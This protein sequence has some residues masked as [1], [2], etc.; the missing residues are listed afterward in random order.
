MSSRRLLIV[1]G[2]L[3]GFLSIALLQRSPKSISVQKYVAVDT[4]NEYSA[5]K[6][7]AN[8]AIISE[9]AGNSVKNQ[10]N[11][12]IKDTLFVKKII[13]G[14]EL[15]SISA[16]GFSI[17]IPIGAVK[18]EKEI[19]IRGLRYEDIHTLDAS[20]INVT[21][22]YAGYR[23]L[24]H[25]KF[26][27]D[28][29]LSIGYDTSLIPEGYY[30][31]DIRTFF[32]DEEKQQWENLSIDSIDFEKHIIISKTDHFTDFINGILKQPE[33]PDADQYAPTS[34]RNLEYANPLEGMNIM[35]PPTANNSGCCSM[36]FPIEVPAG[37]NGMTPQ[38][39]IS[40]NSDVKD[41]IMG[42]G[43]S[44]NIPSITVDTRWGVPPYDAAVESESYLVNGEAIV[45][46]II[47]DGEVSRSKPLYVENGRERNVSGF[48]NYAYLTEGKFD[49]ITRIGTSPHNYWWEII[50]RNGMQYIFGDSEQENLS[51]FQYSLAE[52]NYNRNIAMWWLAK[53]KD[54]HGN[55]I[56]YSY[57]IGNNPA[58]NNQEPES[59]Y[60]RISEI[61]YTA[62]D[63]PRYS[64]EASY[65]ITFEYEESPNM[66]QLSGMYGFLTSDQ[67]LL[68][69][70]KIKYN[71]NFVKCYKFKYIEGALSKKVLNAIAEITNER[72][73]N[74]EIDCSNNIQKQGFYVHCFDYYTEDAIYFEQGNSINIPTGESVNVLGYNVAGESNI[75]KNTSYSIAGGGSACAGYNDG[76]LALKTNT[77]GVN[78]HYTFDIN[79][80]KAQLIDLNG[81]GIVDRVEKTVNNNVRFYKG[82]WRNGS[83]IEFEPYVA[84]PTLTKL[85]KSSSQTHSVGSEMLIGLGSISG[86]LGYS[87]S[88]MK[89]INSCYF[90]DVNG[91]GFVDYVSD[92]DV[93]INFPDEYGIPQ[94]NSMNGIPATEDAM[95]IAY[96]NCYSFA[97]SGE[98]NIEEPEADASELKRDPVI[99]WR[100]PA[101]CTY[102]LKFE[103]ANPKYPNNPLI[104]D[105]ITIY[106]TDSTTIINNVYKK[107]CSGHIEPNIQDPLNPATNYIPKGGHILFHIRPEYEQVIDIYDDFYINIEAQSLPEGFNNYCSN[108]TLLNFTDANRKKLFHYTYGKDA[109]IQDGLPFNSAYNGKIKW[110]ANLN[111]WHQMSDTL[112]YSVI[113]NIYHQNGDTYY[114]EPH[115]VGPY[116]IS[117]NEFAT[118]EITSNDYTYDNNENEYI[119][120][121]F[122][123]DSLLVSERDQLYFRLEANSNVDWSRISFTSSVK[124]GEGIEDT[125][126][127][128]PSLDMSIYS[129]QISMSHP[130]CYGEGSYSVTPD[131]NSIV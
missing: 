22:N 89:T 43:W 67:K 40:Y 93:L 124:Y 98:I 129:R 92:N 42:P 100:S 12:D 6:G 94:F 30:P 84:L 19:T 101:S 69:K 74:E 126:T 86:M 32:Y 28:L 77:L 119:Y 111:I 82:K 81:D 66:A 64:E 48:K 58:E 78:Y 1:I 102:N 5:D 128:Y 61:R 112:T 52:N 117:A 65:I 107:N 17:D 125:A 25:G 91:D 44:L 68:S 70:I 13:S 37:R 118:C 90:M 121:N 113:H 8:Y 59:R 20:I 63:T 103:I 7:P 71:N 9:G 110:S 109:V 80:Q 24:P 16:D 130:V 99:L 116:R 56:Y 3:T 127:Y 88:R 108:T 39:S 106:D 114:Y 51:E 27:K 123:H 18:S 14:T 55:T 72:L 87:F 54:L 2:L 95:E 46:A 31:T 104:F 53:V 79:N 10:E 47:T 15:C 57:D 4:I 35:E 120:T 23:C 50:D 75:S 41:G 34:I 105:G 36:N 122:A 49:S 131:A 96:D 11:A 60:I 73:E 97:Y 33:I 29:R 26:E 115:V 85:S 38:I 76:A 62:Y 45:E 21:S 83:H